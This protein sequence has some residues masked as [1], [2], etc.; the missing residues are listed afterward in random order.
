MTASTKSVDQLRRIAET[1]ETEVMGKPSHHAIDWRRSD[2]DRE[3]DFVLHFFVEHD[4]DA[5]RDKFAARTLWLSD[6]GYRPAGEVY[7]VDAQHEDGGGDAARQE[8]A[9]LLT[10]EFAECLFSRDR[11]L[12]PERRVRTVASVQ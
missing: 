7:D 3:S 1:L 11:E 2:F 8:F 4:V 10:A 5:W 9:G 6:N 12:A